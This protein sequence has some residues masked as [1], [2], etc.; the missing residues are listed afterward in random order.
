[1]HRR[2][3]TIAAVAAAVAL[4]LSAAA[5][6]GASQSAS[7]VAPAPRTTSPATGSPAAQSPAA[8]GP[9]TAPATDTGTAPTDDRQPGT[10]AGAPAPQQH[11]L[12]FIA[13]GDDGAS[14]RPV[15]CGDS[16]VA[17]PFTTTTIAPLG[18]V[19]R[20]QLAQHDTHYGGSGLYNALAQS[21]LQYVGASVEG[22][23]AV[24]DL[25]G[26]L[27]MGGECDIPRVREQLTAPALGFGNVDTVE[28]RIDG[29][30]LDDV[31]SLRN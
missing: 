28:V 16:S 1:M 26:D 3:H 15:G 29:R 22:G 19:M 7:T 8:G 10:T 25:T 17:V 14:G 11:A 20:A 4:P 5:C 30:A 27:V 13:L 31:L 9:A 2:S 18:E 24:V 23:H 6:G 12:V 21:R